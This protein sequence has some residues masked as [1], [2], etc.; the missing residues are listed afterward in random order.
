M[1]R[2]RNEE[3]DDE[4]LLDLDTDTFVF[5]EVTELFD[6]LGPEDFHARGSQVYETNEIAPIG[7]FL[8][9]PPG[10]RPGDLRTCRALQK[11]LRIDPVLGFAG[12]PS[13]CYVTSGS[14]ASGA[15]L[16]RGGNRDRVR[17]GTI[18]ERHLPAE[19]RHEASGRH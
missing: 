13:D 1:M 19:K 6:I 2:V 5:R 14:Y 4:E 3:G 8:V 17:A 9:E 10:A 16:V 18:R 11:N 7:L 12:R 15:L